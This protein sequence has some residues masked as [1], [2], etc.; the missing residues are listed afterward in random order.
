M[1]ILLNFVF[2]RNEVIMGLLEGIFSG[3]SLSFD[4]EEK[5]MRGGFLDLLKGSVFHFKRANR[6]KEVLPK[7]RSE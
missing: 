7:R 2:N 1:S 5:V 4:L 3:F 6:T